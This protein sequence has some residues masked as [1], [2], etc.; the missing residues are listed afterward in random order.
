MKKLILIIALVLQVSSARADYWKD[1]FNSANPLDSFSPIVTRNAHDGIWEAGFMHKTWHLDHYYD[2]G[3]SEWANVGVYT[4]WNAEGGNVSY[5]PSIGVSPPVLQYA[6]QILTY[7]SLPKLGA[8]I[9]SSGSVLS[10]NMYA[11]YRPYYDHNVNDH[12]DWGWMLA[13][14][15]PFGV[16]ELKNGLDSEPQ[17]PKIK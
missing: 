4:A 17:L 2:G 5:G 1:S 9:S 7:L 3:S 11:G 6:G 12:L 10:A 15:F 8:L 16:S 14:K 13:L